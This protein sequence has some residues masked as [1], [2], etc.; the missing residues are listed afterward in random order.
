MASLVNH[1]VNY[2]AE[3]VNRLDEL[4]ECFMIQMFSVVRSAIYTCA[5]N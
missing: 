5:A 1:L 3:F 4:V 2:H